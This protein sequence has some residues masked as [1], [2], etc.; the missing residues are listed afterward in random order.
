M[1]EFLRDPQNW[2][3]YVYVTN[4]PLRYVDPNGEARWATNPDGSQSWVGDS[5]GEE[6][7][8]GPNNTNC[9]YWVCVRASTPL[10]A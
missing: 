3:K 2:N 8:L 9:T 6:Q 5:H 7:C 4:N 10:T 1:S